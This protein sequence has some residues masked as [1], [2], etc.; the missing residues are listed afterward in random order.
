MPLQYQ[1]RA[2]DESNVQRVQTDVQCAVQHHEHLQAV[3]FGECLM[4]GQ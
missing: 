4:Y 1:Q 2:A 3:E